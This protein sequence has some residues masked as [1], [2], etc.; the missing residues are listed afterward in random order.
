MDKDLMLRKRR[1]RWKMVEK[2]K[3]ER[4]KG[5]WVRVKNR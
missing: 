5:K 1:V 2:A 4:E 3:R